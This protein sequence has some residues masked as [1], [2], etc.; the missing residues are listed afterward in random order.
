M[1]GYRVIVVKILPPDIL[2]S[3]PLHCLASTALSAAALMSPVFMSD[4]QVKPL[5]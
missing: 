2:Q 1:D 4:A 3:S 5:R